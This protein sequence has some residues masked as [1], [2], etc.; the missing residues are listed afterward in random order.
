MGGESIEVAC[1]DA[2]LDG[3]GVDGCVVH[4]SFD[5]GVAK[6]VSLRR[7]LKDDTSAKV[8]VRSDEA[9]YLNYA[10]DHVCGFREGAESG[11]WIKPTFL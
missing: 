4:K 7:F 10:L 3:R 2:A 6:T 5:C 8:A 1:L 9:S 11:D